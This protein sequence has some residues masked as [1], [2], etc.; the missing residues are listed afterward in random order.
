MAIV[1]LRGVTV[2]TGDCSMPPTILERS[3]DVDR[4]AA[5][6]GE[7]ERSGDVERTGDVERWL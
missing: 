6:A 5:R 1:S 3:G 4:S 2:H 7:V